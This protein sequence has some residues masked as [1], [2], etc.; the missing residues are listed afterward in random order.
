MAQ[1]LALEEE[2]IRKYERI[3]NLPPDAQKCVKRLT[4]EIEQV[5]NAIVS[6]KA[7]IEVET[8]KRRI[9]AC[10]AFL[11]RMEIKWK[12]GSALEPKERDEARARHLNPLNRDIAASR[13]SC[14]SKK[15]LRED[16]NRC[17]ARL[18]KLEKGVEAEKCNKY[19]E[20][21]RKLLKEGDRK[22]GNFQ[23]DVRLELAV[24]SLLKAKNDFET[25]KRQNLLSQTCACQEAEKLLVENETKTAC[26][27]YSISILAWLSSANG[28]FEKGRWAQAASDFEKVLSAERPASISCDRRSIERTL[29][30]ARTG[31]SLANS[32]LACQDATERAEEALRHLLSDFETRS[33]H[34]RTNR[35]ATLEGYAK[36]MQELKRPGTDCESLRP[37]RAR[38]FQTFDK[39]TG[40]ECESLNG[41]IVSTLHSAEQAFE[42]RRWKKAAAHYGSAL[43][44]FDIYTPFPCAKDED[45]RAASVNRKRVCLCNAEIEDARSKLKSVQSMMENDRKRWISEKPFACAALRAISA[46]AME[47]CPG[48]DAIRDEAAAT[49]KESCKYPI[50]V[51]RIDFDQFPRRGRI[52]DLEIEPETVVRFAFSCSE[53]R[54]FELLL[55]RPFDEDIEEQ[56]RKIEEQRKMVIEQEMLLFEINNME[57]EFFGWVYIDRYLSECSQRSFIELI[58]LNEETKKIKVV[59]KALICGT[60]F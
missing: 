20:G 30:E 47:G 42:E 53:D 7:D 17:F 33:D 14:D 58:N 24:E 46:K 48:L 8:F 23:S 40:E 43:E 27:Q 6:A 26:L 5:R 50:F 51:K 44:L 18:H 38:L 55:P 28:H 2:E 16:L 54:Q 19:C 60:H 37:L 56:R 9:K 31:S 21:L 49:V 12:E 13:L 39:W 57:E 11:E 1:R 3:E 52:I 29:E 25:Q 10:G 32:N 34:N 22:A 36:Y 41:E 35:H 4:L 59:P 45:A 15:K